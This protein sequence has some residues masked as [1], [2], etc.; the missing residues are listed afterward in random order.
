MY[1]EDVPSIANTLHQQEVPSLYFTG[2]FPSHLYQNEALSSSRKGVWGS[3]STEA[4]AAVSAP[5]PSTESTGTSVPS[6]ARRVMSSFPLWEWPVAEV[7]TCTSL[8]ATQT[9][10]KI[11]LY[12]APGHP[13]LLPPGRQGNKSRR[14]GTA[15]KTW[16][17]AD[18][19]CL[20]WQTALILA[21]VPFEVQHIDPLD[22][23]GP[24]DGA[25][26]YSVPGT[27][28]Y[29]ELPPLER[30]PRHMP[31]SIAAGLV[32]EK[33]LPTWLG[34]L[35]D[36]AQGSAQGQGSDVQTDLLEAEAQVWISLLETKLMA[37]VVRDS[38]C[39]NGK[40]DQ[41]AHKGRAK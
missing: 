22:A 16:A 8:S 35:S 34:T 2:I 27:L 3:M 15:K 37:G 23:W 14:N 11:K 4:P 6:W 33:E 40:E 19:R 20:R 9:L 24:S 38:L 30:R 31:S 7:P 39:L 21:Q 26:P 13:A 25:S 41:A 10:D 12:V 29:L 32:S 28:P 18:P 1:K 36:P 5:A 17:S